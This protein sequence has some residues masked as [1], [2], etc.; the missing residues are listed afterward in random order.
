MDLTRCGLDS[1][2]EKLRGSTVVRRRRRRRRRKFNQSPEEVRPTRCRVD[3]ARVSSPQVDQH[4]C[5]LSRQDPYSRIYL[6]T[7]FKK[8]T[9]QQQSEEEEEKEE[10]EEEEFFSQDK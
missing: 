10:E 5:G 6:Y 2:R 1:K 7:F 8:Y 3:P 9:S 4:R